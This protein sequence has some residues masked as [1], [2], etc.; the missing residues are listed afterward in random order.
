MNKP[1]E[2]MTEVATIEHGAVQSVPRDAVTPMALLQVAMAQGADLQKLEKLMELQERWEANEARKAFTE[3]LSSFKANPPELTKNK[4]VGFDTSKGRTEYKHATLDQ[5]SLKIGQALSQH[6]L[7]HRWDVKQDAGQV[8]VT[9]V[10]T[11][12]QGHSEAVTM[13]GSPDTS[14][15]KN[16]IQAVGSTVTYLQRYTLLAATGMAV[17]DQDNDGAG[18]AAVIP[19]GVR[20]DYESAI[21]ALTDTDSGQA[22]W[23]DIAAACK[24][25]GDKDAYDALKAKMTAKV[26][27]FK[28]PAKAAA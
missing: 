27:T 11:H 13:S 5:V 8:T 4:T 14:G 19:E 22:L 17:K 25:Y 24:Q 28:K 10:L 2:R 6:G 1:E 21:D 16:S 26:A 9:C 18:A 3:A 7:S 23:K 12:R 20:A 15:T